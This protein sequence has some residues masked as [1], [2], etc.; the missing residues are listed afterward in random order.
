M[1]LWNMAF[2]VFIPYG[3]IFHFSNPIGV[4]IV[5][6]TLKL[7]FIDIWWYTVFKSIFVNNATATFIFVSNATA[8]LVIGYE[9]KQTLWYTLIL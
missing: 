7:L 1:V 8:A 6:T 3:I 2:A 4:F 5:F 9:Y